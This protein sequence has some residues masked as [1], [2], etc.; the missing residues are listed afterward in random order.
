MSIFHATLLERIVS[1]NANAILS[2]FVS[3]KSGVL[4]S[5][6]A[7]TQGMSMYRRVHKALVMRQVHVETT[8]KNFY[9]DFP[10]ERRSESLHAG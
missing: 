5:F 3:S 7:K 9:G 4:Q 1:A 6:I 2:S 10:S 8:G